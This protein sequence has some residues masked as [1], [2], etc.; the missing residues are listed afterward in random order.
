MNEAWL[1]VGTRLL[2]NGEA[3]AQAALSAEG[4]ANNAGRVSQ[5][6]DLLA[7]PRPYRFRWSCEALWTG[8]PTQ[9]GVLE[10]YI[11]TAPDHDATQ[12]DG[13]VGN[14]DAALADAD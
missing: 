2:V 14:A 1:A 11:A 4:L 10:L 7:A 5:Q 12:I 6:I 3:S 9:G 8:T 13:D